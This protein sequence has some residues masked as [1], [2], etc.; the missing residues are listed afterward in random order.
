[1][2]PEYDRFDALYS[3][4]LE[5]RGKAHSLFAGV[6]ESEE[7]RLLESRALKVDATADDFARRLAAIPSPTFPRVLAKLELL[8]H[9]IGGDDTPEIGNPQLVLLAGIRAD[10]LALRTKQLEDDDANTRVP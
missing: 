4:W 5:A 1:M 9:Y 7:G 8:A 2:L 6:D 3:A 10:V